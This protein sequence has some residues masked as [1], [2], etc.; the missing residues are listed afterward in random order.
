L[1]AV[2]SGSS[3]VTA[4][5]PAGLVPGSYSLTLVS[6]GT[7]NVLPSA[8]TV[9]DRISVPFS[10]L[11]NVLDPSAGEEAVFSFDLSGL[12]VDSVRLSIYTILGQ[13]VA[14]FDE[15]GD[16]IFFQ[17]RWNGRNKSDKLVA[18]G[19]YLVKAVVGEREFLT[20]IFVVK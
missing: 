5:L 15:P 10:V 7:T 6:A 2:L 14:E 11:D 18:S 19:I 4:E 12:E 20:R 17:V 13:P 1:T 8:V 16:Q 3:T 9:L